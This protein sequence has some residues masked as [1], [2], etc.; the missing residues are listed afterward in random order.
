MRLMLKVGSVQEDEDQ[1]GLADFVMHVGFSESKKYLDQ[2]ARELLATQ[3][4]DAKS[5]RNWIRK[6]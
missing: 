4:S 3:I 2:D 6:F 5:H 1:L